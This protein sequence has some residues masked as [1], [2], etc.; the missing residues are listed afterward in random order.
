MS[1]RGFADY[2]GRL[3]SELQSVG[4]KADVNILRSDAGLMTTR[5]ATRNPIYAVLS[6]VGRRRRRALRRAEGRLR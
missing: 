1:G 5:E 6:A 2:V 3:Q 4:A